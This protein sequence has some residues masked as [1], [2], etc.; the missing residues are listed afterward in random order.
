MCVCGHWMVTSCGLHENGMCM[1]GGDGGSNQLHK[2][3]FFCGIYI[4]R[5]Q[6]L[7]GTEKWKRKVL[8]VWGRG[9]GIER[10]WVASER[11]VTCHHCFTTGGLELCMLLC[12]LLHDNRGHF[13]TRVFIRTPKIRMRYSLNLSAL[14]SNAV[15]QHTHTLTLTRL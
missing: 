9:R 3:K 7:Q 15:A 13:V 10:E 2:Q 8:F 11:K 5:W 6:I 12:P 14:K 4:S 1:V